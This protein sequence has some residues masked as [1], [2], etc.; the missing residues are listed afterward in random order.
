MSITANLLSSRSQIS[1]GEFI[2]SPAGHAELPALHYSIQDVMMVLVSM[3]KEAQR[4]EESFQRSLMKLKEKLQSQVSYPTIYIITWIVAFP[5]FDLAFNLNS[6]L[7]RTKPQMLYSIVKP[8]WYERRKGQIQVSV[9]ILCIGWRIAGP[10]CQGSF[11]RFRTRLTVLSGFQTEVK[12][13]LI[14]HK[15]KTKE[16]NV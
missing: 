13:S 14:I 8:V 2:G 4:R 1:S 12:N 7:L 11:I 3:Q 16:I 6:F 9:C 15:E 10:A 5:A